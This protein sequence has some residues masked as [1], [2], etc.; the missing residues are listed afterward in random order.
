M[1]NNGKQIA[2]TIL[3][4]LGGRLFTLMTGAKNLIHGEDYLQFQIPRGFA[5]NRATAVRIKLVGDEHYELT[6]YKVRGTNVTK[7]SEHTPIPENL[8]EIF[9][10]ETGLDC[11][12]GTMG[13]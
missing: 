10:R 7:I 13:K 11:S 5:K 2:E 9:T 3:E 12:L 6:F 1:N 4:Q 8:R